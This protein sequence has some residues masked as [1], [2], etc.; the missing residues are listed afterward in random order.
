MRRGNLARRE[1]LNKDWLFKVCAYRCSP[2]EKPPQAL[3]DTAHEIRRLWNDFTE[4]FHKILKEDKQDEDGKPL[5]SKERRA[6][7]WASINIKPLREIAKKR[8]DKLDIG[9]REYVV[10]RFITTVG[11]WR[12]DPRQ[13]GPPRFQPAAEME[14]IYIPLVYYD[15]K[16]AEWL[17]SGK[18]TAWVQ[19][20]LHIKKNASRDEKGRPILSEEELEQYLNN[21]H[22]CVGI[23]REKLNMHVEYGGRSGKKKYYLP[24]K[25]RIKQVALAGRRDSAFGWSWSFQVRLEYPPEPARLPTGRVCGWDSGG[26]RRMD[27]GY[28]RLGV[29]ADNAGH[30][31]EM[32]L[33]L[34]I[35]TAS[36]RLRR[37]REHCQR[38]GWEF[39]KPVNFDD[40]EALKSRYGTALD[41]CKNQVRKIFEGE[42]DTWPE[43]ARKMVFGITRMRDIGLRRLRRLLEPTASEAKRT[44]DDWIAEAELSNQTIRA[45]DNHVQRA[46]R[47]A[48]RQIAAWMTAFDKIAWEAD[49]GLKAMAEQAGKKKQKRKQA[50]DETGKWIERAPEDRQLEASQRYRQIAGL[51]RLRLFVKE[52]HSERLQNEKAALS[53]RTCTECGAQTKPGSELLLVCKNGHKRDQDA[54]ASLYLLNKIE[55]YA[56]ISAPPIEIPAHLRPYLRVME[57]SEVRLELVDVQR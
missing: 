9:C 42:K 4:I 40:A 11:N 37:E 16:S 35:G 30:F 18:G 28:I 24:D 46:K 17:Q 54:T 57:A 3:W 27:E 38:Q 31:Y 25:C 49:L 13:F 41:S 1:R 45:F 33:P 55:G 29:V 6:T 48:Y 56:R 19:D 20:T 43:D 47:N 12:K 39:S 10:T 14:S 26:W 32:M 50:H 8:K 23:T 52:K 53:T 44:I 15:G 5:L 34:E 51:Y 36:R 7:L 2:R 21:S 22:F